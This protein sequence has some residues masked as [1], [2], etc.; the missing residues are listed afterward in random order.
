MDRILKQHFHKFMKA[1]KMPPELCENSYCEDLRLF[2]EED[3]LKEWQNNF[4]GVS[5]KDKNGNELHGAVDNI[6]VRGS[7][8][9][10]SKSDSVSKGES[11]IKK[12][13]REDEKRR[14]RTRR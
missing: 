2:G 3:L 11:G 1:G 5:W 6:L 14:S 8:K 4:K 7:G 9:D 10:K 13:E 12:S